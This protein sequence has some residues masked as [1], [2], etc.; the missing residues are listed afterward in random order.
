MRV[1]CCHRAQ[2]H[3]HYRLGKPNDAGALLGEDDGG[4]DHQNGSSASIENTRPAH[5]PRRGDASPASRGAAAAMYAAYTPAP[6]IPDQI[7]NTLQVV[8]SRSPGPG[9]YIPDHASRYDWN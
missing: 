8:T 7:T 1:S 4:T 9:G 3:R 2:G 5:G 6:C